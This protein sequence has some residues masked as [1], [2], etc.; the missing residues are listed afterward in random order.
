MA[1]G[2]REKKEALLAA[3]MKD[4]ARFGRVDK[5]RVFPQHPQGVC[6]VKFIDGDCA[7]AAVEG[8]DGGVYRGRTLRAFKWDGKRKF[9]AE[10]VQE[11]EEDE[12]RR[13]EAFSRELEGEEGGAEAGAGTRGA[14]AGAEAQGAAW[15]DDEDDDEGWHH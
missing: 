7:T 8:M 9:A 2:T 5:V 4:M 12:A 14:D 10:K 1:V 13:L 3:L 6:T 11:T 15:G